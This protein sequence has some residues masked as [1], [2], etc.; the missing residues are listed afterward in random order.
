MLDEVVG[1]A[2]SVGED[3]LVGEKKEEKQTAGAKVKR[4]FISLLWLIVAAGVSVG[5]AICMFKDQTEEVFG[6]E[7]SNFG[8]LAI[9]ASG[10]VAA[11]TFLVPYLRKKGSYTRYLGIL[12]L[13]DAI[14]WIY[15]LCS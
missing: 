4:F 2:I 1:T 6:M 3:K 8:I 11:I 13:G 5:G 14:W 10:A 12:A 7:K 9:V 15:I